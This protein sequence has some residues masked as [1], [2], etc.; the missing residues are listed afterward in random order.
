MAQDVYMNEPEQA[1]DPAQ[2]AKIQPL[3][4]KTLLALGEQLARLA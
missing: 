1:R 2:V 4:K 3:L